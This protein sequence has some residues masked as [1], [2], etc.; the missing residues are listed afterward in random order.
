[1]N[2]I[3]V[4]QLRLIEG[5]VGWKY[6]EVCI[7]VEIILRSNVG[8]LADKGLIFR[9]QESQLILSDPWDH[10]HYHPLSLKEFSLK[11]FLEI[12]DFKNLWIT[13]KMS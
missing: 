4:K 10:K 1:L 11:T 6:V 7:C 12:L 3:A 5:T 2:Y 13:L 9:D 8:F